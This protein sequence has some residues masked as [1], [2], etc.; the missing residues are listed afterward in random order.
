MDEYLTRKTVL[1]IITE[2]YDIE[3][4][5]ASHACHEIFKRVRAVPADLIIGA[6]LGHSD[7]CVKTEFVNR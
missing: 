5:S 7:T 4:D 3:Y 1:D 2:V 6:D